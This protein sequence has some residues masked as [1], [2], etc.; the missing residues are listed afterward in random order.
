[1]KEKLENENSELK[2]DNAAKDYVNNGYK[3]TN[4]DLKNEISL[5]YKLLE[6]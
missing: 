4:E 2:R 1:M 6:K 5:I 3:I